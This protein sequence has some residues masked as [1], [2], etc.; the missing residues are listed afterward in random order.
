MRGFGV[1]RNCSGEADAEELEGYM[2][3]GDWGVMLRFVSL[4]GSRNHC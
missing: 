2:Y 4:D 1:S 3:N